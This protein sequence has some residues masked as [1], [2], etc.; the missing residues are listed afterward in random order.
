MLLKRA[1]SIG[2]V[3]I[4]LKRN[5]AIEVDGVVTV[6]VR[7]CDIVRNAATM[8]GSGPDGVRLMPKPSIGNTA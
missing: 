8:L 4:V 1:R 6:G 5:T 2:P 7:R 3:V